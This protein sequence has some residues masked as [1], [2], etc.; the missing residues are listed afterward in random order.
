MHASAAHSQTVECAI[1]DRALS[2]I[3]E[4][5][6][7][8]WELGES[9]NPN[10]VQALLAMVAPQDLLRSHTGK[11]TEGFRGWMAVASDGGSVGVAPPHADTI[12]AFLA[13]KTTD[14]TDLCPSLRATTFE[15]DGNHSTTSTP[16]DRRTWVSI[17]RPVVS[18][19]G[20]A[21]VWADQISGPLA[22]GSYLVL[23][24]LLPTG[25][26]Q[27]VGQFDIAVS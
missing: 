22:A 5:L 18:P 15:R 11:Y 9:G 14:A 2:Y 27:A 26:W 4:H 19:H 20:E 3:S 12:K 10:R 13:A 24:R 17:L 23:L 25:A 21:I 8:P 16:G 7:P 1:A 6:P